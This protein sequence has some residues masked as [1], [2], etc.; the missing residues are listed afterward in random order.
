MT[1]VI[2]IGYGKMSVEEVAELLGNGLLVDVRL[3][4]WSKRKE[5]CGVELRRMF[6]TK[7][8][9]L[10]ELGNVNK[11]S[12]KEVQ[13][14][15]E[16]KGFEILRKLGKENERLVIMCCCVDMSK[17]HRRVIREKLLEEVL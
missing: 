16:E 9:W 4:N 6:G 15:D 13:L 17:C 1:K 5:F 10:R 12:G 2:W 8:V 3:V 7:Y 14:L 11:Y